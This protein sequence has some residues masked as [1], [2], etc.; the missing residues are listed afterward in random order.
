MDQ[1]LLQLPTLLWV[2]ELN[3]RIISRDTMKRDVLI[4]W[5]RTNLCKCTDFL[6]LYFL[7]NFSEFKHV[8]ACIIL[9]FFELLC[10]KM[11][12]NK[13]LSIHECNDY[14]TQYLSFNTIVISLLLAFGVVGNGEVL[15]CTDLKCRRQR[16]DSLFHT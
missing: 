15:F 13:T 11:E 8:S 7:C 10:M 1:F 4:S 9:S 6:Y 16:K 3:V 14:F 2:W 5:N 12:E